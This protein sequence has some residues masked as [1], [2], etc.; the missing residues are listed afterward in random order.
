MLGQNIFGQQKF[1]LKKLGSQKYWLQR[2][3][4]SKMILIQ[5]K[6][7]PTINWVQKVWSILGQ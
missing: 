3:F 7:R 2:K 4:S 5:K 1:G 6:I